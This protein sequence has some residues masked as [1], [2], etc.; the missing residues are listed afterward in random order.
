MI[1]EIFG[2]GIHRLGLFK[3]L[4]EEKI[5]SLTFSDKTSNEK[6][7]LRSAFLTA[8]QVFSDGN[9]RTGIYY[10]SLTSDFGL[11]FLLESIGLTRPVV[12]LFLKGCGN[13]DNINPYSDDLDTILKV[14]NTDDN[15]NFNKCYTINHT[16]QVRELINSLD[17]VNR[18]RLK[19]LKYKNKYL[20]FRN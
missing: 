8:I 14:L 13:F 7:F 20:A 19:Y 4:I 15:P 18:Y 11:N 12:H 16:R 3:R 17:K 9:N 6:A 1:S 2:K 5:P 10:F